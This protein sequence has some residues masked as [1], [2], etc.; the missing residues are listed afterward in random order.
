M[1]G[2]RHRKCSPERSNPFEIACGVTLRPMSRIWSFLIGMAA[3]ALLLY[4][5]MNFHVLRSRDGFH[6]VVKRPARLSE[7][8]VDI[9]EFGMADWTSHPQIATALVQA[10]KQHLLGDSATRSIHQSLNQLLP[11]PQR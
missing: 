3:G 10:N 4:T 8:Y 5:A 1:P 6:L 11:E 9:R 7:S 2:E